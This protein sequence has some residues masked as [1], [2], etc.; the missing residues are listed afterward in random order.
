M[1]IRQRNKFLH[2]P[3]LKKIKRSFKC[4]MKSVFHLKNKTFSPCLHSLKTEANDWEN[5]KADHKLCW[6]FQKAMKARRTGFISVIEL[7]FSVL[8]KEKDD[9]WSVHVY[10]NF[11]HE[12]VNSYNLKTPN[13]IVTSFSCFIALWKHTCRPIKKHVLSKLFYELFD[14]RFRNPVVI[15]KELNTNILSSCFLCGAKYGTKKN[16]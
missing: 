10:Y 12:T 9:I 1:F 3:Y 5:S 16:I 6:D 2:S 13:H 4:I 11:F 14:A 8:K 15:Q 7:S